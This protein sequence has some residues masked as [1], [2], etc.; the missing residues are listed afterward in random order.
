MDGRV[1]SAKTPGGNVSERHHTMYEP[2]IYS[3]GYDTLLTALSLG[4]PRHDD[5]GLP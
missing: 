2:D 3:V 5:A 4:L 1:R